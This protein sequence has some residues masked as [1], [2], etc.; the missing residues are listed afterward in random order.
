MEIG[1]KIYCVKVCHMLVD[2]RPTTTLN[3]EYKVIYKLNNQQFVIIDDEQD[4]HTF[5]N[6]NE[7]FITEK[8]F[9]KYQRKHKIFN[10]NTIKDE[11]L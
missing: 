11:I 7:Y 1:D 2:N 5:E 10:I 6:I 9:I 4:S 8:Q 3:K